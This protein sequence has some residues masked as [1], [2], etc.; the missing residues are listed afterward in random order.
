MAP[1]DPPVFRSLVIVARLHLPATSRV[2]RYLFGMVSVL[3]GLFR[4]LFILSP[5]RESIL[6]L[7]HFV[8]G[9]GPRL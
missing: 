1:F 3:S 7:S 8:T 9:I 6:L 5:I 2:A 4:R